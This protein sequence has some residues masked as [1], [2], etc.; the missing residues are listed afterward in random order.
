MLYESRFKWMLPV[1]LFAAWIVAACVVQPI[2]PPAQ[3]PAAVEELPA[4]MQATVD[5][6]RTHVAAQLQVAPAE[7]TVVAA[8]AVEW[9]DACLGAGGPAES[10]ALVVTPGYRITLAVDGDEYVYH[11]DRGPYWLRLVQGPAVDVGTPVITAT[12]TVD[13]GSC[14]D[15]RIGAQGVAFGYCGGTLFGGK[16]VADARPATLAAFVARYAPFTANTAAGTITFAGSGD[17][18]ATPA[19][20]E[21]LAAWT[22]RLVMEAASGVPMGGMAW[23]GPAQIGGDDTSM[24]ATMTL[25]GGEATVFDCAG[26]VQSI[27]LNGGP[28]STWLA[29]QDRLA[30]FTLE[31][32]DERLE[33]TGMGAE[34][35]QAWQR[36]L[37][38]WARTQYFEMSSGQASA[39]GNTVLA[40]NLGA[41][42]GDLA[43]CRHLTVL[44]WGEAYAET[45]PCGGGDVVDLAR[46]WLETPDLETLDGWLAGYAPLSID[47]GYVAGT[48]T[49]PSGDEMAAAV[50]AW[51]D[52]VWN[53]VWAS[54]M[55]PAGEQV[56]A[57][58]NTVLAW[59][60]GPTN[61]MESACMH[62]TVIAG[63]EA[64]AE[65]RPCAGG[66][67]L[68]IV[69]G[70]LE[71]AEQAQLDGWLASYA[72]LY[73]EQGYV[74]G[75]GTQAPGADEL[76]AVEQW[77]A[78]VWLRLRGVATPQE[79]EVASIACPSPVADE[80]VFVNAADGYCLLLP[81]G[82]V[83]ESTAPGNTSIVLG[84]IMNHTD[85]RVGIEV[86]DGGG[87]TL[88]QIGDQLV[89]DYASGFAVERGTTTVGNDEALVLDNL[90]GQD[91]N[92]RVAVL[93]N[94]RLYSF[95][96]TPLGE[97]G[98]ARAAFEAFYQG[99]LDSFRFLDE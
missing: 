59:D 31:T 48:G 98:D 68:D 4:E 70:T 14:Q 13:N 19:E 43:R 66:D 2:T 52:G 17:Q 78:T 11:T 61:D 57:A 24:C 99:T 94:G 26:N 38:A 33:F 29:F 74:A 91:I 75:T 95:F 89:A 90:P 58:G 86:T 22:Q 41:V 81:A 20:Q 21:A 83:A 9:P 97:E 51:A 32:A 16:F 54:A 71:P 42:E 63:G 6:L 50:A 5:A 39:A 88:A 10:C 23:N 65:T 96:F 18:V 80:E 87:R 7:V 64:Y 92:R 72:A 27:K 85:P 28:L 36:A 37:L 55:Q 56:S 77:A 46:G 34:H 69:T 47:A 25:G 40:W 60:L 62:L 1:L 8:E 44:A 76:A 93:H 30:P 49:Q 82:Y 84:S 12:V 15:A 35:S 79:I 53:R 67:V 73:A 45:R 3:T